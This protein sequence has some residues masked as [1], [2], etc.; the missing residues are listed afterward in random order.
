MVCPNG[1]CTDGSTGQTSCLTCMDGF[2]GTAP[3]FCRPCPNDTFYDSWVSG[4]TLAQCSSCAL[5]STTFGLIGQT[6]CGACKNGWY[7]TAPDSC[8]ACAPDYYSTTWVAGSSSALCLNCPVGASTSGASGQSSCDYCKD[9]YFGTAPYNCSACPAETYFNAWESGST[10]ANCSFCPTGYTTFGAVGQTSCISATG[11]P[12]GWYGTPP[13]CSP[14]DPDTY[15]DTWVPG[16]TASD[17][18]SCPL[19]AS[20]NGTDGQ[21]SCLFCKNGYYGN[22]PDSCHA[23]PDDN[24]YPAW[25]PG[26]TVS[27]CISCPSGSTT[28]FS[29]GMASKQACFMCV[30]GYYGTP[31]DNCQPCGINKYFRYWYPGSSVGDCVNCGT[32]ATTLGNTGRSMCTG[33]ASNVNQ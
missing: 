18:S 5:G 32:G 31:P 23:C 2:Y 4:S 28:R 19:G 27:D 10:E 24:Y 21:T 8:T 20:T 17:C 30:D 11:C 33:N 16:S 25:V 7:G 3:D 15:N 14:C 26:S 13:S 1:S 9:G 6:E 12:D 22:A 29:T